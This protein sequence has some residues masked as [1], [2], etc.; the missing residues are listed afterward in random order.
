MGTVDSDRARI[1]EVATDTFRIN[2]VL[3]G[4]P[5]TYSCFLVRDEQ[6]TLV[7]TSFR[8]AFPLTLDAVSSL[9]DPTSLRY[10]V[11]PHLEGDESGALNPFLEV[12]PQAVPVGSPIGVATNLS[13]VAL[14]AP[15]VADETTVLELGAHRLR[16]LITPYVHQWDSML[17][18]DETS[19]TLFSSDVFISPG[20][21]PALASG[22]ESDAMIA[23]YREIG[24][25]PSRAHLDSALDKI[26]QLSPATLACHHGAVKAHAIAS[27]LGALR[28]ADVIG[29]SAWNPMAGGGPEESASGGEVPGAT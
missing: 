6:P 13:D 8:K 5:I 12:A 18:F 25:F 28:Q 19:R 2:I 1:D 15:M 23:A 3:P 7:E 17:A 16:F 11:I 27:Y 4:S 24:I 9:V 22:D 21:G 29:V 14:R 26:E 10:I 20:Q